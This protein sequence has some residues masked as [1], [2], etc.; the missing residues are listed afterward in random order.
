[1]LV[2][3]HEPLA[4]AFK[5]PHDVP[6]FACALSGRADV[7]VTGDKALFDLGA[8]RKMPILSPRQMWQTLAGMEGNPA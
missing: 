6:I 1:M 5:D 2:A 8:V 7:F 4:L 3:A